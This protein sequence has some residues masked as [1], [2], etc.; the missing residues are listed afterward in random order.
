MNYEL[1][2]RLVS[3]YQGTARKRLIT[4]SRHAVNPI[5]AHFFKPSSLWPQLDIGQR[6]QRADD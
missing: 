4:L 1:Q 2:I 5:L 6:W 3:V